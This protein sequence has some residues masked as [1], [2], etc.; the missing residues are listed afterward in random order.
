MS[1]KLYLMIEFFLLPLLPNRF[2]QFDK[3]IQEWALCKSL[4][5]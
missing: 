5:T 2:V 3:T 1:H 4:P